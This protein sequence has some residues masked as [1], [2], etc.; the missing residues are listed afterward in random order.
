MY[1]ILTGDTCDKAADHSRS[2]KRQQ[3]GPV[4][5]APL[6]IKDAVRKL[7]HSNVSV[8]SSFVEEAAFVAQL[9]QTHEEVIESVSSGEHDAR[10]AS[11]LKPLEHAHSC[12]PFLAHTVYASRE[13][14]LGQRYVS[15]S[16]SGSSVSSEYETILE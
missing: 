10:L 5:C 11:Q 6:T 12:P 3:G 8:F 14:A 15:S 13:Y 7:Y 16:M 1:P 9:H 2:V 4:G